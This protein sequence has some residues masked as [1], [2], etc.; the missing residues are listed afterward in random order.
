MIE[1]TVAKCSWRESVN[2][3]GAVKEGL[4][5]PTLLAHN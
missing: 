4:V 3:K 1:S 5:K 2:E